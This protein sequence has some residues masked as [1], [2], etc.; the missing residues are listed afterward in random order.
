MWL[1][2]SKERFQGQ[3]KK[4]KQSLITMAHS[5]FYNGL[6]AFIQ[7]VPPIINEHPFR[8]EWW[9][10]EVFEPLMSDVDEDLE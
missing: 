9:K 2:L 6:E 7:L 5:R 3:G 4:L 8:I 1:R 10:V